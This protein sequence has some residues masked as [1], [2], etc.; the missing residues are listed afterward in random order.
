MWNPRGRF[1]TIDV[2]IRSLWYYYDY[3]RR[4]RRRLFEIRRA[5]DGKITRCGGTWRA[6]RE[7]T[8]NT[9]R[10]VCTVIR[11]GPFAGQRFRVHICRQ[12][13]AA[14]FLESPHTAHSRDQ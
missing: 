7:D 2:Y 13:P 3:H 4:R 9:Y 12:L 14:A 6:L 1:A 11:G 10:Y 8:G 5:V